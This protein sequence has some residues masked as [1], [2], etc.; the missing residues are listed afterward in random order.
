MT[1]PTT[2]A[3][4]QTPVLLS[5]FLFIGAALL[6]CVYT[7]PDKDEVEEFYT[8][9]RTL[10]PLQN[11]LAL[12]G[13]YISAITLLSTTGIIAVQGFDGMTLAL[14]IAG[15]LGVLLVLSGP[16]RNA[17]RYTL[18]DVLALRAPGRATRIAAAVVTL[19]VSLP[20]LMIQL[21][22][23]GSTIALLL[24]FTGPGVQQFC[25]VLIG[26][27]MV[28]FTLLGGMKGTSVVQIMKTVIIFGV[29]AVL[30]VIVLN[31]FH[32]NPDE[33]LTSA[34]QGSGA[35]ADYLRSG[36]YL[37]HSTE[38]RLNLLSLQLALILG[39]GVT[40]HMIMRANAAP[41]AASSRRS[42]RY[43][44][45][46]VSVFCVA[47]GIIG[48]GASAVVGH[49]AL[50]A[51][52]SHGLGA[53]L[54]LSGS[55]A[56][57]TATTGGSILFTAVACAVFVTVLAVVAG[58]TLAAAAALAHDVVAHVVKRG[59]VT[60]EVEVRAVRWSIVAVGALGIGL[61]VAVQGF[62]VQ[63]LTS[64][65][66]AE[67]ASA[68]LPSLVYSL[69]WGRFNRTGLLWTVY[70]GL[71]CTIGLFSFSP[72]V[73]GSSSALLPTVDFHW[74]PLQNPSLLSVPTAFLLGWL[75]SAYGRR[76][77]AG[78]DLPAGYRARVLAGLGAE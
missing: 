74:F 63:F 15:A 19:A 14:C 60:P 1:F 43:A 23:A 56:G 57:T 75:G 34:A 13:D 54:L 37:G 52:G 30:A 73:S 10:N 51:D 20:Y 40:P 64:L 22:G 46:M 18:G 12:S 49:S 70:G 66:M 38:G 26:V 2:G 7:G 3:G 16:L 17:G 47:I 76:R 31:R 5:F 39:A 8:A 27:L 58:I 21:T 45:T 6:L 62:N 36:L 48:L 35:P 25:T 72:A 77:S 11:G 33:L 9:G 50:T 32:W 65:A 28:V 4:A 24:G 44:I 67:A 42:T 59:R 69:F 71:A 68:V 55:V 41:D 29:F 61:A 53:L 78:T